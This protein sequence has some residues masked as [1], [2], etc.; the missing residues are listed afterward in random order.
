MAADQY[1]RRAFEAQRRAA[2]ASDPA[3]TADLELLARE[4]LALAEELEWLERRCGPLVVADVVSPRS[5]SVVQQ[6]HQAQPKKT[7]DP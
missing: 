3:V 7:G 2:Q 4:W 6:Q 1:R 5:E